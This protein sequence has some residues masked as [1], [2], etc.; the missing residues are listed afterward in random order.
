[1]ATL[2]SWADEPD[3]R[4]YSGVVTYRKTVVVERSIR[5]GDR[6]VLSFGDGKASA[7]VAADAKE[8][9]GM[10]AE[11]DAP[12]RDAAVVYV[13]GKRAGPVWHAPFEVDVTRLLRA[14]SNTLEVRVA[15]TAI[16]EMAG[17]AQPDYR[18]LWLRYGQRF[19]P[20]DMDHLEPLPSGLLGP[21]RLLRRG[22][23]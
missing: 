14:G 23:Q 20:Q 5:Q 15:N 13:D 7:V 18:L 22:T 16:N 4:F 8:H 1:M 11:L 6:W 12:V 17:T 21:V 2:A 9:P 10:H 19:T 3:T